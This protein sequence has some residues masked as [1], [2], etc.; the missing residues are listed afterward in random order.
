MRAG[1]PERTARLEQAQYWA[2]FLLTRQRVAWWWWLITGTIVIILA[3]LVYGWV[4]SRPAV[5]TPEGDVRNRHTP[6]LQ[7][8]DF[9]EYEKKVQEFLGQHANDTTPAHKHAQELYILKDAYERVMKQTIP[10][11]EQH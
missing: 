3:A 9:A 6:A 5:A 11:E 2:A 4:V 7:H 1:H 10:T 8:P